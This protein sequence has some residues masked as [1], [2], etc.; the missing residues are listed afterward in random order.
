[1]HQASGE[2]LASAQVLRG[3]NAA[4]NEKLLVEAAYWKFA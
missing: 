4:Q 1:M 2:T 3:K